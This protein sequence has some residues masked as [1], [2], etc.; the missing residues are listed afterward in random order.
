MDDTSYDPNQAEMIV[1][2]GINNT[3][4]K[5]PAILGPAYF[6]TLKAVSDDLGGAQ[7][8]IGEASSDNLTFSI[9]TAPSAR[10]GID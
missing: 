5:Q 1:L 8:L 3:A 10:F 4:N 9:F 2:T 6:D 7:Y